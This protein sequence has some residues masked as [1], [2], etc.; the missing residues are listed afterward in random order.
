MLPKCLF[1]RFH[2]KILLL[3]LYFLNGETEAQRGY[4]V[5]MIESKLKTKSVT[6]I[7]TIGPI[8]EIDENPG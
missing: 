7:P 8:K 2:E 6:K 5:Y 3:S 1:Y 4:N